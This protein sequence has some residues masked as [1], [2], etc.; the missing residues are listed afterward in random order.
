M[1]QP[2]SQNKLLYLNAGDDR[3][4]CILDTPPPPYD[5]GT[6]GPRDASR[7]TTAEASTSVTPRASEDLYRDYDPY[8]DYDENAH[9]LDADVDDDRST[10]KRYWSGTLNPYQWKALLHLSLI[11]FPLALFAWIFCFVGSVITASLLITLPIGLGFGWVV[12][13][14]ARAMAR[15]ELVIQNHFYPSTTQLL[16]K[17]PIFQRIRRVRPFGHVEYESSFYTNSLA[18]FQ[19]SYSYRSVLYFLCFRPPIALLLLIVSATIVPLSIILIIP[20]PVLLR[21]ATAFGYWQAKYARD[22]LH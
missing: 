1:A 12:L 10:W 5:G 21:L 11:S 17:R 6:D 22:V 15:F 18:M 9:L 20:L 4:F 3:T 8:D 14:G 7:E 2:Q 13:V 19:D 16:R